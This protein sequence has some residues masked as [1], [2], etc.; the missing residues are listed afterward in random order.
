M[1][2][3]TVAKTSK[4]RNFA[5]IVVV[6]SLV[7]VLIWVAVNRN[8][9]RLDHL[10]RT[11]ECYPVETCLFD[12]NSDGVV[13]RIETSAEPTKDDPYQYRLKIYLSNTVSQPALNLEK[14]HVDNTF[15]THLAYLEE[16]GIKKIVVY[17][18]VNPD[19]FFYWDGSKLLPAT[20]PSELEQRIRAAMALGDDTG[21][22]N[23]RIFFELGFT[24]LCFAYYFVLILVVAIY[25]FWRRSRT[26][27]L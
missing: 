19:Q 10:A 9:A 5:I 2:I 22:F 25:W 24:A 11:Y 21:G 6:F 8:Y 13:D 20:R 1:E 27:K 23:E 4:R 15:R 18:T 26:R 7:P 14:V 17:D 12:L 16:N 3:S